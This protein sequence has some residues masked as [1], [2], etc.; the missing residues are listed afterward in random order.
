ML[1]P[2]LVRMKVK[3]KHEGFGL[4][5]WILSK[6]AEFSELFV[7]TGKSKQMLHEVGQQPGQV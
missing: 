6:P 4:G 5:P 2:S 3:E 7:E 1:D